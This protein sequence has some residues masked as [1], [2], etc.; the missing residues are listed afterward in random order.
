MLKADSNRSY[1][2]GRARRCRRNFMGL[3]YACI[4]LSL[5]CTCSRTF[6]LGSFSGERFLDAVGD[7][8]NCL[9]NILR[10]NGERN[11]RFF[12]ISSGLVPF[13]DHP[14]CRIKWQR[15]FRNDFAIIGRYIRESG[16]RVSMH[17]DHFTILNSPRRAVV[18]KSVK[19]LEY[20][21]GILDLLGLDA[22]HKIQ[23][24]VG[25]VYGD[26]EKS[27][28][29]FIENYRKLSSK[30]KLRLVLENDD[31]S[32]SLKDCL[33]ISRRTGVP[34]LLD[35]FH[36]GLLCHGESARG[37][38]IAASRTWKSRDGTFMVD[39]SSQAKRRRRGAHADYVDEGDFRKFL[40]ET[41]GIE[42]DVMI[43]AK[44][45][46]LALLR[47]IRHGRR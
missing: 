23:V 44:R 17:P 30:I 24:H 7:N 14:V 37:A 46:N 35:V 31:R 47:L 33:E 2:G 11:I 4:N 8:L 5:P 6:R 10:W 13:A 39:F 42:K 15:I 18:R 34:V 28:E 22:T 21:C 36:H 1:R 26:R 3:G 41:A 9:L 19:S 32:F 20:H 45:K 43:E 38:A 16:M 40:W 27:K 25:G 29:R 12:R